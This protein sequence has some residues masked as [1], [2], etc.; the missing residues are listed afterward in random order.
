MLK[1]NWPAS[2]LSRGDKHYQ[3]MMALD[4]KGTCNVAQIPGA[5]REIFNS[6]SPY[7][8]TLEQFLGPVLNAA[9][10]IT[11]RGGD[12]LPKESLTLIDG[13][14]IFSGRNEFPDFPVCWSYTGWAETEPK[15]HIQKGCWNLNVL[16]CP[17]VNR[18]PF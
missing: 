6:T 14:R 5:S 3:P 11:K 2:V 7:G 13:T 15:G 17:K 10:G 1:E 4:D 18:A 16:G 8:L 12:G 9:L